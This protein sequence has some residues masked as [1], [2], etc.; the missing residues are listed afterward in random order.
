MATI[1][2][3]TTDSSTAPD[4]AK[5]WVAGD[6]FTTDEGVVY[7]WTGYS[8]T[9]EG[10]G[11]GGDYL[12]L[13]GGDLTG[14]LTSTSSITAEGTFTV[15]NNGKFY[16]PTSKGGDV[17]GNALLTLVSD[18]NGV[19]S[20]AVSI[21]TDGSITAAGQ[22]QVGPLQDGCVIY[23]DGTLQVW[24]SSSMNVELNANGTITA[25]GYSMASLN[26]L[27]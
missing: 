7:T 11:G 25:K 6:Q 12:P 27:S 5:G 17:A 21:T 14:P 10:S 26:Q 22:V 4:P 15:N 23:N 1:F 3:D 13:T 20:N 19:D 24:D 9:T 18:V 2:P 8:W 16:R